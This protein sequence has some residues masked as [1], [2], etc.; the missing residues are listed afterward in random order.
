[1]KKLKKYIYPFVFSGSFIL[2]YII[3]GITLSL[4][5]ENGS[6][7]GAAIAIIFSFAWFLLALPFYCVRYIKIIFAERFRFL[8]AA[9][10]C[11]VLTLLHKVPFNLQGNAL[12]YV[13][14]FFVWT[15]LWSFIPLLLKMCAA[16]ENDDKK[17]QSQSK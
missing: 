9:Y 17:E 4:T 2:L 8:F 13:G 10:N 7:A 5:L 16:K 11:I 1:M 6:Y 14:C 15:L 3:L 12:K